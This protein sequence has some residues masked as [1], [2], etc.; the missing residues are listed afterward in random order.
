MA[1][2][3]QIDFMGYRK[4][5]GA[6]SVL[7]VLL[8]IAS[9]AINQVEWGLDFTGGSLVEVEY[10]SSVDPELIRGQL[11]DAGYSGHVV[12]FLVQTAT[13]W[14]ESRRRKT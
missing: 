8:S 2:T 4:I 12:Q 3:K 13:F 10:T 7:V 9:L 1:F 14:F 5:A 11:T 6:I